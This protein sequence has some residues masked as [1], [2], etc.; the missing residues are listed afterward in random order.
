MLPEEFKGRASALEIKDGRFMVTYG[1]GTTQAL[2]A[3]APL[4]VKAPI[5]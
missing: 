5:S 2:Q 4:T 3:P 1:D